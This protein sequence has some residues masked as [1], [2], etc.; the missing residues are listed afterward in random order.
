MKIVVAGDCKK[1]DFMLATAVLLKHFFN[2]EVK[3]ITDQTQHYQ[4]FDGEVSGITISHS[5]EENNVDIV[6]YDWHQGYPE[7]LQDE[8]IVYATTYDRYS[9]ENVDKLLEQHKT[10]ALLIVVEEECGL[11][12]KYIDK[13]FPVIHSKI[14]Y[15]DNPARRIDWVHDGRV[16][17]KVD[18]D[19]EQAVNDFVTEFCKVPKS[20]LKKL[21][22]YARKR[23]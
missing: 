3:I 5:L 14:S 21:W 10:P 12:L 6:L 9:L 1:Y 20:D 17:L 22:K 11:G 2:N 8:L 15:I 19:F 7:G 4:Y 18:S 13:Y 16:N 23:G